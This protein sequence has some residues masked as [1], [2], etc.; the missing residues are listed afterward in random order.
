MPDEYAPGYASGG[1]ADD[2]MMAHLVAYHRDGGHQ[3]PGQVR[4]I[5]TGQDDKIP[6]WLSDG[7]YVIDAETVALL[8]DGSSKAGAER[9]DQFRAN[10]RKQKGKALSRGQI[11]PDAKNPEHYLMGGRA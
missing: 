1:A 2:D 5:G 3:G 9:L 7:E 11:S 6:A 10:I 4:G 8:G